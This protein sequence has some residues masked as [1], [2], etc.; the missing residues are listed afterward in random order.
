MT[1]EEALKLLYAAD[2]F[3]YKD[4]DT[5][6]A[7]INSYSHIVDG[8]ELWTPERKQDFIE[9]VKN[10]Q[11][12]LNQND[13]WGWA[14]SFGQHVPDDKL[15]EVAELYSRYGDCGVLY[16]VSEQN[17]QMRSEFEDINRYVD[18]VRM[19]EQIKKKYPGSSERAYYKPSY[20]LPTRKL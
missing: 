6:T 17:N 11:H 5:E 3:Y 15:V 1:K 2:V 18:F 16:W 14:L 7:E 4:V 20:R 12:T 10:C 13:T 19:E 9:E 8:K